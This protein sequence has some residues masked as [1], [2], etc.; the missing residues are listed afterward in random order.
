MYCSGCG[1]ALQQGQPVCP[2]CGRQTAAAVPPVPGLQYQIDTYA[3]KIR[4][5]SVFWFVYA[6]YTLITGV[7]GLNFAQGF[8]FNH[9]HGWG[10]G[11]WAWGRP[12]GMWFGHGFLHM[13]WTFLLVRTGM[14][15]AAGWL[16]M[17]HSRPGRIVALAA[18]FICL[19]HPIVGTVLGVWTL[20]VLLGYR[21]A[22][23]YEQ[24][25]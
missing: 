18:A 5:L 22:T 20:A 6:G 4:A 14:A 2:Q 8:L 25:P 19:F 9:F 11:Y 10:P 15:L 24:L 7:I 21:N 17:D 12:G 1:Q 3:G 23:L 16:L 13:A